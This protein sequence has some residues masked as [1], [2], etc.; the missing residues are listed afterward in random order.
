MQSYFDLN[1]EPLF[2][3]SIGDNTAY[4][5]L[6]NG[7]TTLFEVP[8]SLW[9]ECLGGFIYP[10]LQSI[11]QLLMSSGTKPDVSR[12]RVWGCTAYVQIQKDKCPNSIPHGEVCL[13]FTR[14]QGLEI[15]LSTH[16]ERS[17]ASVLNL[18]SYFPGLKTS[19]ASSAPSC[20]HYL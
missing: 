2:T 14:V 5:D 4:L 1:G 8:G 15:L 18:M 11:I 17:S 3:A 13:L 6:S 9:A 12:I 10:H 19:S 20:L 7:V 16:K